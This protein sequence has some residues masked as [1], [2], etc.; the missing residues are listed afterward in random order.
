M[1]NERPLHTVSFVAAC[2]NSGKTTLIEKV[3][4]LLKARGLRVAVVK[5]TS[6]GFELDRPG[7]DSWR[8][9]E[10]GADSVVLVSPGQ[11]AVIRKTAE[12][13]SSEEIEQAAGDVDLI[14]HEGSR[15]T[16]KNK[17]EV[18]RS[19]VSGDRPLCIEDRSYLALV[20][21]KSFPVLIPRFDLD[22]AEGVADYLVKNFI[23]E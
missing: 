22:D 15:K 4:K 14:I 2:S 9:Q 1:R 19:A 21:D 5:H 12:V 23:G 10:A 8:F 7:K 3:V 6:A 11:M 13:P 16:A 18:F 20:S 17:I